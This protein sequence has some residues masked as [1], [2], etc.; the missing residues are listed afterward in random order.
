[1]RFFTR[2][3][4]AVLILTISGLNAE[5][6]RHVKPTA[7]GDLVN[8]AGIPEFLI[9]TSVKPQVFERNYE[10][11]C[12]E[13]KGYPQNLYGK[14]YAPAKF[15]LFQSIGFNALN[16]FGTTLSFR[17]LDPDYRGF[18]KET[19]RQEALDFYQ[20]YGFDKL[21][22]RARIPAEK[23]LKDYDELIENAARIPVY[24]DLHPGLQAILS[25]NRNLVKKLLPPEKYFAHPDSH[26]VFALRIKLSTPEGRAIQKKSTSMRR[27][28]IWPWESSHL[29]TNFSTR[30]T[31]KIILRKT[32][33]SSFGK[34]AKNT[35]QS[36]R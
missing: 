35:V 12:E 30:Q 4:T 15:P 13:F 9:S 28:T 33:R 14:G 17:V 26:P 20:K 31:T 10:K 8:D 25:S 6:T 21:G 11:I 5:A 3:L 29:S 34:C 7:D 24:I 18:R 36:K 32:I 23:V 22:R 27:N 1:M 16:F 2:F 19:Q